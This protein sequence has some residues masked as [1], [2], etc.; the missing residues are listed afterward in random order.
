MSSQEYE[1]AFYGE[2]APGAELEDCKV[3]LGQLFKASPAQIEKMFSGQ[4]V[5]LKSKLDSA[6][7]EKYLAA[8]KARGA[9]CKLESNTASADLVE[10]APVTAPE[11]QESSRAEFKPASQP[12]PEQQPQQHRQQQ[13]KT[14]PPPLQQVASSTAAPSTSIDPESAER[15]NV[16][17]EKVDEVLANVDLSVEPAGVDLADHKEEIELPELTM[18]DDLSVAPAGSDLGEKKE[19]KEPVSPDISHLSLKD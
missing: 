10:D 15:L 17:G 6:T 12:L 11:A 8:L 1:L 7:G 14:Q 5:V 9:V 4:R 2:L 3:K 19:E 13:S 16:A 18:Q